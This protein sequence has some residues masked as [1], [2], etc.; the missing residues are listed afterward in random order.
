MRVIS[1]R[2]QTPGVPVAAE[3]NVAILLH[4]GDLKG[5]EGVDVVVER[6]VG[7]PGREEAR[8]VG[9]QEYEGGWEVGVVVDYVGEVGHGFS[10]FVHGGCEGGFC[11]GG[12]GGGVDGV[13]RRLPAVFLLAKVLWPGEFGGCGAQGEYSG[14]FWVTQS[15]FSLTV[16]AMMTT[17]SLASPPKVGMFCTGPCWKVFF[18]VCAM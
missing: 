18:H 15:V 1:V 9:V 3:V 4:K 12:V 14:R 16:L 6:G 7:V 10:A 2:L 11:G 8:A 17:L 13:N 5:V